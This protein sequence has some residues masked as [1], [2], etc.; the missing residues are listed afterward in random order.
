MPSLG[1]FMSAELAEGFYAVADTAGIARQ[2]ER[3]GRPFVAV[4]GFAGVGKST[5]A[6]A[7]A[8]R[9]PARCVQLDDFLPDDSESM[10][11][12]SYIERLDHR[13]L[14]LVFA[15]PV[16]TV[17]EGVMLRDILDG[18]VDHSK[19]T[20]VYVALCSD[21]ASRL[22]WHQA[23]HLEEGE[24]ERA[25]WFER[26]LE[27]DVDQ[28]RR[29]VIDLQRLSLWRAAGQHAIEPSVNIVNGWIYIKSKRG[30]RL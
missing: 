11:V 15:S 14:E 16:R 5:L 30:E 29:V 26:Q 24:D 19:V 18:K 2:V 12:Q 13:R 7:L 22:T 3:L 8:G 28:A 17:I 27:R 4:E 1:L 9:L 10:S 23:L 21:A 6:G 25:N 20:S